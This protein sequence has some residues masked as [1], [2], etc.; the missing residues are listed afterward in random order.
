MQIVQ[1][2]VADIK[3][4]EKNPRKN[5]ASVD[6]VANSIR[7][8]GFKQP[9]VIDKNCV[10]VAGHTRY[11]AAKKLNL[12]EVPCIMADD[13]TDE[14]IK[15]YRLADNKVGETSD[16]DTSLLDDELEKILNLD[17]WQFGFIDADNEKQNS[18]EIS[19]N[20]NIPQY[21]VTGEAVSIGDC[22]NTEK[23]I[24]LIE[25]INAEENISEE[26]RSFLIEAAKRHTVFDYR[27]IAEYYAGASKEMQK[28]MEDS[29]L[30][31][32]DFNDAIANGFVVLKE[33]VR[34]RMEDDA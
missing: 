21:E 19:Y 26:E 25:A 2:K 32:I 10:I 28:L 17:M 9:I 33:K 22:Y 18:S 15:A 27:N 4:Y 30:V 16:W 5:D 20:A 7:E 11:K 24:Q 3:P 23:T 31:I 6:Y 1:K 14:Q 29:A 34:E 12:D 13:L 8:F